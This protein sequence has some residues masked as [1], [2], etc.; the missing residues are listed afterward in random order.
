[1]KSHTTIGIICFLSG[2]GLGGFLVGIP[3]GL[4]LLSTQHHYF[5]HETFFK[6][7]LG[8]REVRGITYFESQGIKLMDS[9]RWKVEILRHSNPDPTVIYTGK[10]AFQEALPRQPKISIEGGEIRIE[11]GEQILKVRVMDDHPPE[12]SIDGGQIN[13]K[14]DESALEIR[15]ADGDAVPAA[16]S[17]P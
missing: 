7:Q 17:N 9:A 5:E 14:T 3:L 12:V 16:P 11:D 13:I 10:S 2:I 4:R 8:N 1:M 6:G 15:T